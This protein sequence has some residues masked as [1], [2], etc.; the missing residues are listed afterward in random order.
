[1]SGPPAGP[2]ARVAVAAA[3]TW[4]RHAL[5]L[6]AVAASIYLLLAAAMF[7]LQ[8]QLQYRPDPAPVLPQTLGLEGAEVLVLPTA[9]G[10]RLVAWWIAPASPR[11]PVFLYLHGNGAN[12]GNRARRFALL[13]RSGAGVLAVSWRGY[14]G[15]SGQP[16]EA[17]L[18]ADARAGWGE[19]RR[20]APDAAAL[21]FGESLGTGVAVR[22]AAELNR[23]S[24]GQRRPDVPL[25]LVLDSSYDSALSIARQAYPWLPVALLLRDTYRADLDA[26]QVAQ[27]VLQVHC[28]DDPVIPLARAQ[29]LGTALPAARPIHRLDGRCHVA[30][31]AQW[32]A[33]L[34]AFVQELRQPTRMAGG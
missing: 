9:D 31:L 23:N 3:A 16:T 34:E 25:G 18:L 24:R 28:A 33:V 8:R 6:A 29:A 20:R 27:P 10:E 30:P 21:L 11:E 12:L 14:G 17:G 15:S 5:R 7:A 4:R 26:P 22:L 13:Q 32:Q 1:M 2:A 19:L